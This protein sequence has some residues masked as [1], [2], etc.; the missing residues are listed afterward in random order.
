MF[1]QEHLRGGRPVEADAE[2][3]R[4][5]LTR[6][7]RL[8]RGQ[9]LRLF[10]T[11]RRHRA[12]CQ[13]PRRRQPSLCH[14]RQKALYC[15]GLPLRRRGRAGACLPGAPFPSPPARLRVPSVDRDRNE[16][17]ALLVAA[18]LGSP[19]ERALIT[20]LALNGLRVSEAIGGRQRGPR[21]RAG[22]P[23]AD[24]AAQRREGGEGAFGTA[25]SAVDG[26]LIEQ[27]ANLLGV[28]AQHAVGEPLESWPLSV[29]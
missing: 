9:G 29:G 1:A 26:G 18:G 25:H 19:A 7:R 15:A 21:T 11:R 20:L 13:V 5:R 10:A 8:V 3:T 14:R 24:R 12:F 28:P 23:Y 22:P 6:V 2:G 16:V 17:V 27:E 4:T